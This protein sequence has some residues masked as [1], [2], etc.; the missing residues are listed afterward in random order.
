MKTIHQ[1]RIVLFS[2]VFFFHLNQSNNK[3]FDEE[4]AIEMIL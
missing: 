4:C 2:R 1:I 3:L